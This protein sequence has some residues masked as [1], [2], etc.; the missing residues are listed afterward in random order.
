MILVLC[1]V[2]ACAQ[3]VENDPVG[4]LIFKRG[5]GIDDWVKDWAIDRL[6][7]SFISTLGQL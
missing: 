7:G 4:D 6:K 5:A 1:Y 2:G 3:K